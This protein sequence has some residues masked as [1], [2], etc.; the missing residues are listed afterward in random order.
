MKL[1]V[2][3]P[4]FNSSRWL[5]ACVASV[6]HATGGSQYEHWVV[7]GGSS[8]GTRDFLKSKS[9]VRWISEPDRG[10]YDAL[11]K[12]IQRATGEIIGHLNADEQYNRAGLQAALKLLEHNPTIDAVFGPT[13]LVNA[14]SHF[15][16]LFKQVTKPTLADATWHMPVQSCS[17]IYRKRL[18]DRLPY[19][20]RFRLVG[21]HA[22]F[23][24]QMKLGLQLA[25]VREPIGIFT[26]RNDNLSNSGAS[27]DALNGLPRKTFSLKLAKHFYRVRKLFAGGYRRDPVDYEIVRNGAV[28]SEHVAHPALKLSMAVLRGEAQTRDDKRPG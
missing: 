1:S 25:V 6:R 16:Q 17:L 5:P 8:D 13:V 7:D 23:Y 26:W 14:E 28:V 18:W 20:A 22:W 2:I 11:N 10:M 9:G 12:G 24:G 4:S 3:T 27:E 19:D 15:L 21:D